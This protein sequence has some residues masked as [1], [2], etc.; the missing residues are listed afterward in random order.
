MQGGSF[1]NVRCVTAYLWEMLPTIGLHLQ[2]TNSKI[3][4]VCKIAGNVPIFD[5]DVCSAGV[6]ILLLIYIILS[7]F[8]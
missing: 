6:N 7:H 1:L 5:K 3:S 8:L 2:L 4:G